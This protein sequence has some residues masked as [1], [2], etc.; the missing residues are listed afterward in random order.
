MGPTP[1]KLMMTPKTECKLRLLKL[2]RVKDH[3]IMEEEFLSNLKE[4]NEGGEVEEEKEQGLVDR[5]RGCPMR[6]GRLEEMIDDD[7]AIVATIIGDTYMP[8]LSFVDRTQLEPGCTVLVNQNLSAM[9]GILTDDW[10]P[11]VAKMRLEV[12]PKETYADL[13]GLDEQIQEVKECLELPLLRPEI[14]HEMGVKPPK[15]VILYGPPGTGKTLLAKAVANATSATF[16]RV[17]GSDLVQKTLGEGPRLVRQL[18]KVAEE[19]APSIVFIDEIDAVGCKRYETDSSGAKEVQRTMIELLTQMDGFDSRENVRI[20]LATNRIDSLDPALIRPGRIDRKIEF[21]LPNQAA[22]RRIFAIHTADMTL[23]EN[24][25]PEAII[26][27]KEGWTGADIKALCT[28]AGL[29]AL[30]DRRT[31]VTFEDFQASKDNLLD[32]KNEQIPAGLYI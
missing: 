27:G 32:L 5:I 6:L 14:F 7:H 2:D 15:G 28:E 10:E 30:R 13:G 18:F 22:L 29:R 24:V 21:P 31:R 19:H 4:A 25:D 23:A 8:V 9:V 16:L 26:D 11:D 20:V 12:A 3:L 17:A 1:Q